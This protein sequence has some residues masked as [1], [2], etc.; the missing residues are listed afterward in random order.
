MRFADTPLNDD[1]ELN[2]KLSEATT[3]LAQA[4]KIADKLL[5][6]IGGKEKHAPLT[7]P[8]KLNVLQ[9]QYQ[10]MEQRQYQS[11]TQN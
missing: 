6:G 3:A 4:N 7:L 8:E 5:R 11:D 1:S 10:A 9:Q 2:A